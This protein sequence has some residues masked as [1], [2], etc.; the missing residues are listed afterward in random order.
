MICW[1]GECDAQ[2]DE[3][4]HPLNSLSVNRDPTDTVIKMSEA[5]ALLPWTRYDAA[6]DKNS[7]VLQIFQNPYWGRTWVVQEIML[8]DVRRRSVLY[9]SNSFSWLALEALVTY[10]SK[11]ILT[12]PYIGDGDVIESSFL[13]KYCKLSS[14]RKA[15]DKVHQMRTLLRNF[16]R[17]KCSDIR[18]RI[19][20]FRMILNDPSF[21]E[22][23]YRM[24][25][26]ELFFVSLSRIISIWQIDIDHRER[27]LTS[28]ELP[29]LLYEVLDLGYLDIE[30]ISESALTTWPEFMH[31]TE[32]VTLK[33]RQT[34]P[35]RFVRDCEMG[36]MTLCGCSQCKSL[37]NPEPGTVLGAYKFDDQI[38]RFDYDSPLICWKAPNRLTRRPENHVGLVVPDPASRR[39]WLVLKLPVP[40]RSRIL[41]LQDGTICVE[42]GL[43]ALASLICMREE[44][45]ID[46]HRRQNSR[47]HAFLLKKNSETLE[48][49]WP[50]DSD[51]WRGDKD[52][53]MSQPLSFVDLAG[54]NADERCQLLCGREHIGRYPNPV[55]PGTGAIDD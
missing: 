33:L 36:T 38:Y 31:L 4:L 37:Y 8:S 15:D 11:T 55:R 29:R 47:Y 54:L 19:F 32:K 2:M 42:I 13:V 26:N 25:P 34:S 27:V 49:K 12:H 40:E 39:N 17:I 21:V 50:D 44:G 24:A 16:G 51:P 20:A 52:E 53:T 6:H 43:S 23:D 5:P 1:L 28:I 35:L 46:R 7:P 48:L 9:G 10:M 30:Q 22:V 45:F 14:D 18:D 41:E 3:F